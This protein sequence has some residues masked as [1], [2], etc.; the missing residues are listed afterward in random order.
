MT[1]IKLGKLFSN[2]CV[3]R[4]DFRFTIHPTVVSSDAMSFVGLT[5]EL[6]FVGLYACV[7]RMK[8]W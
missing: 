5:V 6:G 8:L 7:G 3:Y 1:T 2:L 4:P